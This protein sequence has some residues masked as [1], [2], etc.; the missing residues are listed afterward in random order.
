MSLDGVMQDQNRGPPDVTDEQVL[1]W[2]KNML[3]GARNLR[4][5]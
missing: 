3:T 2:Y 5:R 1:T 4:L